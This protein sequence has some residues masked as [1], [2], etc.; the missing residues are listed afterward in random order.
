MDSLMMKIFWE[1]PD[2]VEIY[3]DRT[4]TIVCTINI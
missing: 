2:A 4:G 3:Y 1:F